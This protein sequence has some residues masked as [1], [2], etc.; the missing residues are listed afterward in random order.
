MRKVAATPPLLF[1]KLELVAEVANAFVGAGL[2]WPSRAPVG[3]V[4]GIPVNTMVVDGVEGGRSVTER[5]GVVARTLGGRL[6]ELLDL[7]E[8]VVEEDSEV[9]LETAELV[10]TWDE[11]VVLEVASVE[12]GVDA[13]WV[14]D[15]VDVTGESDV[16]LVG[17]RRGA[18]GAEVAVVVCDELVWPWRGKIKTSVSLVSWIAC[19]VADKTREIRRR[20]RA[21]LD[22]QRAVAGS[23]G[24]D[25]RAGSATG[26]PVS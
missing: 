15:E 3:V 22:D 2:D 19:A 23:E 10:S 18:A 4:D 16:A 17:G 5:E 7:A 9:E 11:V 24:K 25:M 6:V 1:Q 14:V 12:M 20:V 13:T 21:R 8:D 26:C